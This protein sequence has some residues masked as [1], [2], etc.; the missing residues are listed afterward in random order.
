MIEQT[1][2]GLDLSQVHILGHSLG[3]HVAGYAGEKLNGQVGRITGMDPAGSFLNYLYEG[4]FWDYVINCF[5]DLQV[6]TMKA[7]KILDQ[8]WIRQM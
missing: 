7:L 6:H 1:V 4:I 3:S 5:S 8:N 2:A